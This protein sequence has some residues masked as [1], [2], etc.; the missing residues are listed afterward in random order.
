[1]EKTPDEQVEEH[2]QALTLKA[3]TLINEQMGK[4]P[5]LG[6]KP[7]GKWTHEHADQD[8]L[9]PEAGRHV[10]SCKCN[11]SWLDEH[12]CRRDKLEVSP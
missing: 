3:K 9:R 10:C 5:E 1:M 6:D 7:K 2:I 11:G 12:L 4:A 8:F